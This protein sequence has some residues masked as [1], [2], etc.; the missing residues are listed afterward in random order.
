VS[1]STFAPNRA[2]FQPERARALFFS[3]GRG[4][5]HA[6]PD[7]AILDRL[8]RL[9]DDFELTF[10]S[11][12]SGAQALREHGRAVIDL[13]MPTIVRCGRV[14][15]EMQ[16]DLVIS[17]EEFTVL[18]VAKIFGLPT[19][20]ITEWFS[21]PN[22]DMMQSL[23]YA[24]EVI[25][26]EAE[27]IFDEPQNVAGKVSYVGPVL[28]SFSY[29]RGDR[30][31]ARQEL[32]FPQN[33]TIV[34]VTPGGWATE[35]REPVFD[36]LMRAFDALRIPAKLLLWL[37]GAD[38]EA[39]AQRCERRSDVV[40]R[41]RDWQIGRLMVAS[42]LAITKA[43]RIT[44]RELSALGIPSISIS[45][46]LNPID[47]ILIER[48]STNLALDARTLSHKL[49]VN[50]MLEALRDSSGAPQAPAGS[51]GSG[52]LLAARLI[53]ERIALLKRSPSGAPPG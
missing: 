29:S 33:A 42:D 12:G 14:M 13:E 10:V 45:H 19:I 31:R 48:V 6:I 52:A 34:L 41:E 21:E 43:N 7:M 4:Y 28:R 44:V 37:A 2:Y 18:P 51:E 47:D 23:S 16:P 9:R 39:L 8:E 17:H 15:Q 27:G 5:G 26:T 40:V 50:S 24:D 11:Y 1:A 22:D 3:R 46:G 30:E 36:V 35:Q 32:G 25:V 49:L 20:L 38:Y 53:A